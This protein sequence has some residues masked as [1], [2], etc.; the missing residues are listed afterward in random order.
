MDKLDYADQRCLVVE[1]RRPFLTLLKGLLVSLGAKKIDTELSADLALKA[2]KKVS[3]DIIVCDL[4][5]GNDRKNGFEFLEEIRKHNYIS[6]SAV[7]IMISG[8]S[9][10]SMVLGSLEKQPDDYLIKPFSQAQ[11]NSRITRAKN[12]RLTLSSL[13]SLIEHKKYELSIETCKHF[14][15][16]GTKYTAQCIQILV[17]LYWLTKQYDKAEEVLQRQ[18]NERQIQWALSAMARTQLLKENYI[19]AIDLAKQAIESSRNDVESYDVLAEAYLK[20]D[21][22]DEA[23][24]YIKDALSLSPLSIERHY[25][26][27]KIARVNKDYETAM[28]SSQAIFELSQRSVHRNV[29]HMCS[30][31][32]SILDAAEYADN[33]K[34]SNRLKQDAMHTLKKVRVEAKESIVQKGFDFDIFEKL[35]EARLAFLD[36]QPSDSKKALEQAQIKI[37]QQFSQFPISL[38]AESLKSMLDLGDFE[39][40]M[41]VRTAIQDQ[42]IELDSNIQNSMQNA[43]MK[44]STQQKEYITYNKQGIAKFSEGQYQ[45]AYTSFSEAKK[46]APM[47][48]GVTLN[49]LQSIVKLLEM[50]DN[51]EKALQQEC[52]EYYRYINSM[53][54]RKIHCQKFENMRLDIEKVM[55]SPVV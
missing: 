24:K 3:Y 30:Y 46:I 26:V 4:H 49:L 39:D 38:A 7:F 13:Y 55:S 31:I 12:R 35:V 2:C 6:P 40:A 19:D 29:N 8:D 9:A 33:K 47:N 20:N 21:M 37:E 50:T 32:R 48:I 27:C 44:V 16:V 1:D 36:N 34:D 23:L 42:N 54:L 51:P 10:R 28:H 17:Q 14:L 18:L 53:P 11:L 5:L 22:P 43:F 15:D 52:K 25:T 41:K 45:S